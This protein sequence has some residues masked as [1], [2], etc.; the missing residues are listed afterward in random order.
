MS[1]ERFRVLEA[2]ASFGEEV[3]ALLPTPE[4]DFLWAKESSAEEVD[5]VA[6]V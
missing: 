2:G 4:D 5:D 1:S 6:E 3:T